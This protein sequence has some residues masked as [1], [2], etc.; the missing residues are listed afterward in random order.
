MSKAK[1]IKGTKHGGDAAASKSAD[2]AMYKAMASTAPLTSGSKSDAGH[3]KGGG[4]KK[5]H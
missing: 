4:K 3:R 2:A 5:K 1:K